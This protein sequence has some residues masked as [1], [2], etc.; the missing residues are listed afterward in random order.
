MDVFLFIVVLV[1]GIAVI[2]SYYFVL[3]KGEGSYLTSKLWLGYNRNLILVLV[4][5][6]LLSVIGF[7]MFTIPWIFYEDDESEEGKE[8]RVSVISRPLVYTLFLGSAALWPFFV[9]AAAR[10]DSKLYKLASTS[11]LAVT[12]IASAL[13]IVDSS[14]GKEWYTLLG[15]ILLALTTIGADGVAYSAR[16]WFVKMNE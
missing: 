5:L 3:M 6:Q 1:G 13:F 15:T 14:Q 2:S 4:G 11:M 16:Q 8:E 7:L 9:K 10:T 12:G